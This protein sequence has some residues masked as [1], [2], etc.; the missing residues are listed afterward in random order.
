MDWEGPGIHLLRSAEKV[1]VKLEVVEVW[2]Q[3]IPDLAPY[4]LAC[5]GSW[6]AAPMSDQENVYPFLR[7]E[8]TAIRHIV[9]NDKSYLGFCLGHQL[10]D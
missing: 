9:E 5:L 10:L 3:P 2:Y 8:K 6:A 4:D 1:G 7:A